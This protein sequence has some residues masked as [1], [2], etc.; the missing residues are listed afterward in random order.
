MEDTIGLIWQQTIYPETD[1]RT[2]SNPPN[3][4]FNWTYDIRQLAYDI[5]QDD[6]Y[7]HRYLDGPAVP[8]SSSWSLLVLSGTFLLTVA[9]FNRRTKPVDRRKH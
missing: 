2:V 3:Y 5:V 1:I 7:A 8:S 9:R 4:Q 6:P